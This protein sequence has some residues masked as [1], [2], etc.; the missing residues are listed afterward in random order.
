MR[1]VVRTLFGRSRN[2]PLVRRGLTCLL[3]S[4]PFIYNI[5]LLVMTVSS[6]GPTAD[7]DTSFLAESEAPPGHL[8][9]PIE[10]VPTFDF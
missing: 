10:Q 8:G 2:Y 6:V 7:A 1:S 9:A 3:S 5:R 4:S